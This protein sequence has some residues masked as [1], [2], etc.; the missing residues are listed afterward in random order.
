MIFVTTC[1]CLP[2]AHCDRPSPLNFRSGRT[3]QFWM[4]RL[5]TNS[6]S[7]LW[8]IF[9][10]CHLPV[11]A[12]WSKPLPCDLGAGCSNEELSAVVLSNDLKSDDHAQKRG[13]HFGQESIFIR[14]TTEAGQMPCCAPACR[15]RNGFPPVGG[16]HGHGVRTASLRHSRQPCIWAPLGSDAAA[17]NTPHPVV[18]SCH[19][20]LDGV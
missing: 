16:C 10:P 15:L 2:S 18:S 9:A 17:K 20:R 3:H 12:S 11:L 7:K 1:S 5:G 4:I 6:P 13:K 8:Q 19:Y 14:R